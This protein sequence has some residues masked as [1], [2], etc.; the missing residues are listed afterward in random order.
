MGV[1]VK[2]VKSALQRE[3]AKLQQTS[4]ELQL[5][6]ALARLDIKAELSRLESKLRRAHQDIHR[7]GEQ[8]L[9]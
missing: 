2:Q 3:L 5:K 1:D 9:H 6:A 7:I 8:H 4:E